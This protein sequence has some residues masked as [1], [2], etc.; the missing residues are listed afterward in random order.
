MS[1][2][3]T[4]D[5]LAEF[6]RVKPRK[7]YDLVAKEEVP[8]S[9]VMGKLLFS[10]EE[11]ANWIAGRNNSV[12]NKKY[13]PDV[14]LGSHDPLLE[15]AIKQSGSGIALSFDGSNKG[16]ERFKLNQGIASGLHIY[17]FNSKK[18]NIPS[19]EKHLNGKNF[20]LLEWANRQRGLIFQPFNELKKSIKDFKGLRLVTRQPGSGADN[21]LKNLLKSEK[22]NMSDFV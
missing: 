2:Y 4:T 6:L 5:E 13:L 20:V 17:D 16:L 8:F 21:Y 11:V 9:K 1:D 3:F 18:W 14:F 22:L 10:K 12:D 15:Y 7:V 19:V